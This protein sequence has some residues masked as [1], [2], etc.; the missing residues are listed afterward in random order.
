M[1]FSKYKLLCQ[2]QLKDNPL[3]DFKYHS[4][5]ISLLELINLKTTNRPKLTL[6]YG[7]M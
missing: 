1:K 6:N 2:R 5:Y 3:I 7:R 4:T